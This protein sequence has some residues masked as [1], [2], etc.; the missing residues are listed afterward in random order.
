ME[1]VFV[2]FFRKLR[3]NYI[4]PGLLD[5]FEWYGVVNIYWPPLTSFSTGLMDMEPG[6]GSHMLII[7]P[8]SDTRKIQENSSLR[9]ELCVL[10]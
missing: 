7:K 5:N 8:R 10:L 9:L 2:I 3:L 4:K 1:Y 6:S